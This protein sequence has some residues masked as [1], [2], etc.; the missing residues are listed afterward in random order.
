RAA[1]QH[2]MF[3]LAGAEYAVPIDNVLEVGRPLTP[4]PV[5]NV[6]DWVLGVANVRG[7]IV[8]MI[9]LRGFLGLPP[10]RGPERR[11]LVVRPRSEELAVGLLVDRVGGIRDIPPASVNTGAPADGAVAAYVHGVVEADGERLVVLDLERLLLTPE[12][13][14]FELV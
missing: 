4:T 3:T 7:D 9:D 1:A 5:P 14:A 13:R 2:V 11:L 8:S 6:P 10:H 12:L